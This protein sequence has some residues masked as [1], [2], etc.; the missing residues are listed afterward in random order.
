LSLVVMV[1]VEVVVIVVVLGWTR[2]AKWGL[3][4][5]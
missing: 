1:V 5:A 2:E 4:S 3:N